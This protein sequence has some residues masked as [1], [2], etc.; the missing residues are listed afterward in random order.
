MSMESELF[1]EGGVKD[2]DPISTAVFIAMVLLM[3]NWL[4]NPSISPLPAYA[5]TAPLLGASYSSFTWLLVA[6]I[7]ITAGMLV[8]YV[9]E[10]GTFEPKDKA[11]Y[12]VYMVN[13]RFESRRKAYKER[14]SFGIRMR[15]R[16]KPPLPSTKERAKA[17]TRGEEEHG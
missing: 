7:P 3:L 15:T 2:D 6:L 13:Q 14:K 5:Q 4:S 1:P 8:Q 11:Q 12:V 9:V 10:G 16:S 17:I